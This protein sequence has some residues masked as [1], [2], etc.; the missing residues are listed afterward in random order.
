MPMSISSAPTVADFIPPQPTANDPYPGYYQTPSGEWAAYDQ[1]YYHT[2]FPAQTQE[3]LEQG[4]GRVGRHW[5]EFN[6]KGADF[7]DIYVSKGLEEARIERERKAL[8]VKP[9]LPGDEVEYKVCGRRAGVHAQSTP[10]TPGRRLCSRSAYCWQCVEYA[11]NQAVGQ[12]KG[13]ATER[14]QLSSLLNTAFTQKEE[15][16]L[17]L[18]LFY[19]LTLLSH[20]SPLCSGVIL[21]SR[22]VQIMC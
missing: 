10:H 11:D 21:S 19:P 13:L 14:H 8:A 3:E 18:I 6:S 20:V 5:E 7:I 2:F 16:S 17:I 15:V 1:D 9:K 4:D 22:V 12:I